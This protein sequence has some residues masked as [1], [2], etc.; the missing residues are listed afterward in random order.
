MNKPDLRVIAQHA[1]QTI[2][3][4]ENIKRKKYMQCVAKIDITTIY[5]ELLELIEELNPIDKQREYA[6]ERLN[7]IFGGLK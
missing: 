2:D 6:I 3:K 1:Q 7:E 4:L 5:N